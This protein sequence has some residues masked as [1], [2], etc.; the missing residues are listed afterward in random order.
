MRPFVPAAIAA[1]CPF[2]SDF[3]ANEFERVVSTDFRGSAVQNA[4]FPVY[5]FFGPLCLQRIILL[6]GQVGARRWGPARRSRILVVLCQVLVFSLVAFI[7]ATGYAVCASLGGKTILAYG[8]SMNGK[9]TMLP[10]IPTAILM[11]WGIYLLRPCQWVR[12]SDI[13]GG[14]PKRRRRQADTKNHEAGT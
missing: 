13:I 10:Y 3:V 7:M 14:S 1:F 9:R 5:F 6:I 11:V 4:G 8:K 2:L 12:A